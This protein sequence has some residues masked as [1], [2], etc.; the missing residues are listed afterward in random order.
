[1]TSIALWGT[2]FAGIRGSTGDLKKLV[3]ICV[4][5]RSRKEKKQSQKDHQYFVLLKIIHFL[6]HRKGT[7]EFFFQEDLPKL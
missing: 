6:Y 7:V 4:S 5:N 2:T 3:K 1:M